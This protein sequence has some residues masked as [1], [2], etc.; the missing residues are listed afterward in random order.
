MLVIKD[1]DELLEY[2]YDV[3]EVSGCDVEATDFYE[4]DTDAL[5]LCD[6]HYREIASNNSIW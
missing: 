5:N 1:T 4:S 3:C 6:S 2:F